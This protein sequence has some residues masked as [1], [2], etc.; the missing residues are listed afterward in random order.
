MKAYLSGANSYPR[1][2]VG[3]WLLASGVGC[4]LLSPVAHADEFYPRLANHPIVEQAPSQNYQRLNKI[5][6]SISTW[7]KLERGQMLS[8][9]PTSTTEYFSTV[10]EGIWSQVEK[11]EFSFSEDELEMARRILSLNPNANI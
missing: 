7:D 6:T 1:E 9:T 11:G 8:K 4:F 5:S 3:Q 2:G 10:V